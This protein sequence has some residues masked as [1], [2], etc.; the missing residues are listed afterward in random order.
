MKTNQIKQLIL[1]ATVCLTSTVTFAQQQQSQQQQSQQSQQLP[2]QPQQLP[3]QPDSLNHYLEQAARN[4]PTNPQEELP[5][6]E[7]GHVWADII[8]RP[9]EPVVHINS[10][11][12]FSCVMP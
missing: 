8:K 4:N 11:F 5:A 12:H 10:L 1:L 2:Q 7:V 9:F 3:Q 6:T